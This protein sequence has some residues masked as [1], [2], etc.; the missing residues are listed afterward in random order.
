MIPGLQEFAQFFVSDDLA[1]KGPLA[2][3]SLLFIRTAKVQVRRREL[4]QDPSKVSKPT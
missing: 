3:Y 2:Q 1:A 4:R